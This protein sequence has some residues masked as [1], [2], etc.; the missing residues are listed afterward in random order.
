MRPTRAR[1]ALLAAVLL[2]C[3]DAAP[4]ST[5]ATL[6]LN[7]L[8]N[9]GFELV[10]DSTTTPPKYGAC[11]PGA[12][13]PQ[14]GDA[15]SLVVQGQAFAGERRLALP[16]GREVLQKLVA[17][18][19]FTGS[20]P[21]SLRLRFVA[22]GAL[23][24]ELEDG[25]GRRAGVEISAEGGVRDSG[26]GPLSPEESA[27][28]GFSLRA[29][30]PQG[31]RELSLD[32]GAF[33]ALRGGVAQP[34]L[35]LHCAC[36]GAEGSSVDVDEVRA[37]VRWPAITA[38][39]LAAYIEGLVRESLVLW[40]EPPARGGLGLVDEKSGYVLAES[41][42]VVSGKR[43]SAARNAGFHSI[44]SLLV[45]W[46]KEAR[47]RGLKEDVARWTPVLQRS[48]RTLLE[49]N[50]DA[51]SGLPRNV[52]LP[53]LRPQDETAV[54]LGPWIDFLLDAREQVGDEEL[55][56]RCLQ[57]ARRIADTLIALQARHDI[58][59]ER[60]PAAPRWNEKEGRLGGDTSNWFGCIPD[61]LTP[62]GA[63]EID[64]RYYTS[65]AILTGRTFWYEMLSSPAAIARVHALDPRPE[66]L[67]ALRRALGRYH[68]DWDAARYDLENDTDDHY[69]YLAADTLDILEAAGAELPEALALLQEATDHRLPRA[70]GAESRADDALWIQALRLGTPCA[71]D[72]PRA[73]FGPLELYQLPSSVNPVSSGLPL[74]REALLELARNDL[75]GRQLT[76][77]Q[78]TESFFG[79]WEMVCICFR[80]KLQGDCRHP[81]AKGWEGDVGDTFGGPPTSAIDAQ[82]V[83]LRVAR[84]GERA[85]ILAALALIR[86][87]TD[88]S[89]R[90][91]HGWLFGLDETIARQYELPEKYVIGLSSDS[92][93]G[94]GY[95]MAWM[96]LL[97]WLEQG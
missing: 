3:D 32:I 97:P 65:W 23:R 37:E 9:P 24:L 88:A 35:N 58:P 75:Q 28:L 6:T 5:P 29:P 78:F 14:E 15:S 18:P 48:M 86:D 44:H 1:L 11:W 91:E 22:A 66:D 49:R 20:L 61:R 26:G 31:W 87:V 63:I 72:S 95:V 2:G 64:R 47:R 19:R 12:F 33:F 68:R 83:A 13:A 79:N 76:N 71:G 25:P 36:V 53:E 77:A 67:P 74:Y 39:E 94:L 60:A 45:Q 84:P 57:Q 96:R 54:A 50:F 41:Y 43:G 17:D 52:S 51:D 59:P 4:A 7:V 69:G 82:Q 55:A 85:P 27:A 81:P 56:A 10:A 8:L 16:A 73:F 40:F 21:V 34:R 38:P 92:A 30:D 90:R 42:D 62:K 93:A 89:L 70:A 80:G 46:L